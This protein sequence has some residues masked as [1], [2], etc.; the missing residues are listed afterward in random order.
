M[1]SVIAY[2]RRHVPVALALFMALV[3][4]AAW[5]QGETPVYTGNSPPVS[6][7]KA[8]LILNDDPNSKMTFR[9]E[10]TDL[11]LGDIDTGE[12]QA[13]T[14][15][16]WPG[17]GSSPARLV[18]SGQAEEA[19]F[20]G[21]VLFEDYNR[22]VVDVVK[23]NRRVRYLLT[24]DRFLHTITALRS[25]FAKNFFSDDPLLQP[26]VTPN[27]YHAFVNWEGSAP[28]RV[29][30]TANGGN[31]KNDTGDKNPYETSYILE[32]DLFPAGLN[33]VDAVA[34][35][36]D[37]TRSNRVD[38]KQG[39]AP[40][41]QWIKVMVGVFGERLRVK[42]IRTGDYDNEIKY[43]GQGKWP[44][45][46]PYEYAFR[47][48]LPKWVPFLDDTELPLAFQIN[49]TSLGVDQLD[50][51]SKGPGRV[52]A[53][54][55]SGIEVELPMVEVGIPKIAYQL[56]GDLELRPGVLAVKRMSFSG[57]G[58]SKVGKDISLARLPGLKGV[59]KKVVEKGKNL[60]VVGSLLKKLVK[61]L[62]D[63]KIKLEFS[64]KT[65]TT[66]TLKE[67]TPGLLNTGLALDSGAIT[68]GSDAK[69]SLVLALIEDAVD[70]SLGIKIGSEHTLQVETQG[71]NL[72]DMLGYKFLGKFVAD[73][74]VILSNIA[75]CFSSG[76]VFLSAERP[77]GGG[78]TFDGDI[79]EEETTQ[80]CGLDG[81]TR[82]AWTNAKQHWNWLKNNWPFSTLPTEESQWLAD[83][84]PQ[85]DASVDIRDRNNGIVV[86]HEF[87]ND[88]L[89]TVGLG[90]DIFGA[91]WSGSG[92]TELTAITDDLRHDHNPEVLLDDSGQA[93]AIWQRIEAPLSEDVVFDAEFTNS[94]EILY[95]VFNPA[96]LSWTPPANLTRNARLDHQPM[97]ERFGNGLLAVWIGNDAGLL[98]GTEEHPD[99]LYYSLWDGLTFS[100]PAAAVSG[101]PLDEPHLAARGEEALL[102]WIRDRSDV[103]LEELTVNDPF[104]QEVMYT[105]FDGDAWTT[106][107]ALTNDDRTDLSPV[108]AFAAD[109][110]PLVFWLSEFRDE[111]VVE[112]DSG[113]ATVP[114]TRLVVML[115]RFQNGVWTEP[116]ML[117]DNAGFV[118]FAV[119]TEENGNLAVVW[120]EAENGLHYAVLDG[121]TGT[122]SA[123][124][125]LHPDGTI[126]N[127]QDLAV[128]EDRVYVLSTRSEPEETTRVLKNE[129]GETEDV[130]MEQP[131]VT[132]LFLA[133][134]HVYRDLEITED[135]ID[136]EPANPAPGEI[137]KLLI[138]VANRG[139]VTLQGVRVAA[140]DVNGPVGQVQVPTLFAGATETVEILW[141]LPEGADSQSVTV[142]VDPEN[143]VNEW[144]E[145][146][147]VAIATAGRADLRITDV[148]EFTDRQNPEITRVVA[149]IGNSGVVTATD[150]N[151]E[152]R[153]GGEGRR[154]D[155]EP[156]AVLGPGASVDVELAF[157]NA[158][159]PSGLQ[160]LE[161]VV[162][163]QNVID[164]SDENNN[165]SVLL[166]TVR[167]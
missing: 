106:A 161:V 35:A 20:W 107:Q 41:P 49:E 79:L 6:G 2:L 17:T 3:V 71:R 5:S 84:I 164:E 77:P 37:G 75:K 153:L 82:A 166:I 10:S 81:Q 157:A 66:T 115:D 57:A 155:E 56:Q 135:G 124:R 116:Q 52:S 16:Y 34:V 91:Y 50:I 39:T 87:A 104:D 100:T 131:G 8:T 97:L 112:F 95:S 80:D 85:L 165:S 137:A 101:Q 140:T 48:K 138:Q 86:F 68:Y 111:I 45:T 30:F 114:V 7:S 88:K 32:R 27:L 130:V 152:L 92:W 133:A 129:T 102:V 47:A 141:R 118:N 38:I 74:H 31:P 142:E 58:E 98:L 121:D 23:N 134:H 26:R 53:H 4:P 151:V 136:F 18:F 143:S 42:P 22:A 73:L 89:G 83:S 160:E 24:L 99:T 156:I 150:I 122:L 64:N 110:T 144:F 21:N 154:L 13:T 94:F 54:A 158:D 128:L 159:L 90:M 61:K 59:L 51:S 43:Q 109:G 93:V 25:E 119:A 162:D 145:D 1:I 62:D 125:P 70:G 96:S 163:T 65:E 12:I 14:W 40:V 44:A 132:S 55:Q 11:K 108:A 126:Q 103:D 19:R 76:G 46:E 36:A 120:E 105:F 72:S 113:P 127:L 63:A 148:F 69:A 28:D 146:N 15:N 147:N 149:T 123:G 33:A 29:D 167:H 60:P 139:D 78:V 117:M 67:S 9:W